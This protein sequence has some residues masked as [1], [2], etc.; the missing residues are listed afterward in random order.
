MEIKYL[1]HASFFLKGKTATILTDPFDPQMVGLRFP[2]VEADV[3]TVSHQHDD[4]NRSDLVAGN[5]LVLSIPGEYEKK[6]VKITGYPSYHDENNGNERGKNTIFKIEIDGISFLHCGD[7]G[8][9]L[10]DDL[11]EEIDGVD[12][13]MVPVG[14]FFTI[15]ADQAVSIARKIEPSILIPMHYHHEKLNQKIFEQLLP[16]SDFLKKIGSTEISPIKKL[17]IKKEDLGEEMRVILLEIFC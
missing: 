10:S 6:G 5:P 2:K 17:S 13:L 8:H 7:L 3:V 9:P 15:D 4:H 14:G 1:G 11:I 12:V 16:V